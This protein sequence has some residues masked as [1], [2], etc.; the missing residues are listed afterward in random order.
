M[1]SAK[2]VN[3]AYVKVSSL[4]TVKEVATMLGIS[5]ESTIYRML[6]SDSTFPKP[7]VVGRSRRFKLEEI[8]DWLESTRI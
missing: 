6:A 5:A 4:M 2:S 3:V 7:Y 8:N 1:D